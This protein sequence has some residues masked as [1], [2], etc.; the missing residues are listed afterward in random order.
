M[1]EI[2]VAAFNAIGRIGV[3]YIVAAMFVGADCLVPHKY[4][5]VNNK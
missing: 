5:Y 2:A 3:A 4:V 1:K